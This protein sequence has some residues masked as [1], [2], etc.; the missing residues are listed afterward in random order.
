MRKLFF[1]SLLTIILF[2]FS[3]KKTQKY[4][5][6]PVIDFLQVTVADTV[7]QSE[8]HNPIVLYQIVFKVFD[9][10]NDLGIPTTDSTNAQDSTK[11]YNLFFTLLYKHD[12]RFDTAALPISLNYRIPQA[13]FVSIYN[14]MKATVYVDLTFSPNVLTSM[15]DTIKFSFYVVDRAMNKSNTQETPELPVNFRGTLV[16]TVTI[17]Q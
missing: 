17:I 14:Y 13:N 15:F 12:G 10:D 1:L 8:L 7:D 3:C 11:N 6:V 5:P 16:D 2:T 4:S 9:G